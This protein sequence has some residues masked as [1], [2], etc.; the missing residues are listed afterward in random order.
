MP[1]WPEAHAIQFVARNMSILVPRIY[2]AFVHEGET[3]VAM[4]KI[5]GQ[6]AWYG[7]TNRTKE[8]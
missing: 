2:G 6:M 7:W 5:K 3:Y 1:L 8:L 4:S